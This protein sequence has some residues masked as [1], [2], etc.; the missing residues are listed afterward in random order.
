MTDKRLRR[1]EQSHIN[2][3]LKCVPLLAIA[4]FWESLRMDGR[5]FHRME[6]MIAG[7]E[8]L[9]F[10]KVSGSSFLEMTGV[11]LTQISFNCSPVRSETYA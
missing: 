4:F 2:V 11:A 7:E 3:S 6:V 10:P 9:F 5:W 1:G 8:R